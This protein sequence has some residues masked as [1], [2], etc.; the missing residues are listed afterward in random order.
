MERILNYMAES[1]LSIHPSATILEASHYMHDNGIHS[2]LVEESGDYIGIITS[3]D[4][5]RKVVSEKLDPTTAPVSSIM[6]FPI[7]KMDSEKSM[8]EAAQVMRDNN[9]HHLVVTAGDQLL[10]I[11]SISD[12]SKYLVEKFEK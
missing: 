7:I 4:I 2:L 10:G 9:T 8:E 1:L 12:Y 5:S 3:H 6:V 11:L